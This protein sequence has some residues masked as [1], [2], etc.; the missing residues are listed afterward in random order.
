[1]GRRQNAS[2]LGGNH[3]PGEV[4]KTNL[5]GGAISERKSP[6]IGRVYEISSAKIIKYLELDGGER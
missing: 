5:C 3:E 6:V 4:R 2:H 1:M